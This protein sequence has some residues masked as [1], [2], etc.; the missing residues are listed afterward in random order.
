METTGR[1]GLPLL[2]FG[3]GQKDVT[4]NEAVMAIDCLL[5]LHVEGAGLER[6]PASP[7]PGSAWLV[8][9]PAED[10]WVGQEGRIACYTSAGWRFF[11]PATGLA[12]WNAELGRSQRFDGVAWRLDPK[13]ALV[14]PPAPS[15]EGGSVVDAEARAAIASVVERL[16]DL[17]F[18]AGG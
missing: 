3:Q 4:H 6:P 10:A 13:P 16:R 11:T 1:F 9:A 12:V 2:V 15:A 18:F 7:Q 8:G 17:G 5:H 14:V